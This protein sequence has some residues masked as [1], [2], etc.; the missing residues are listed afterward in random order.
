GKHGPP[1][2]AGKIRGN[3]YAGSRLRQ[4]KQ[5]SMLWASPP[6]LSTALS[7]GVGLRQNG[8]R[9]WWYVVKA[10]LQLGRVRHQARMPRRVKYNFHAN[11][12][13][14]GQTREPAFDVGLEDIAHAAAW[15]GHGHFHFDK[16][17]AGFGHRRYRTAV[18][19]TEI[20]NVY[21]N[22]RIKD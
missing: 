17:A 12:L 4:Y 10:Q 8:K 6:G 18:Y 19:E 20:N 21:G 14:I 9:R 2:Q 1:T 7:V 22:F 16:I 3:V 15:G 5:D 13:H 11:F